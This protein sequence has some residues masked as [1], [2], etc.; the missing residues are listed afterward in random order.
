MWQ[1][2]AATFCRDFSCLPRMF[3]AIYVLAAFL[4]A[5]ICYCLFD[6]VYYISLA[7]FAL[8]LFFLYAWQECR[9]LFG[10][11]DEIKIHMTFH[12]LF[13]KVIQYI[14]IRFALLTLLHNTEALSEHALSLFGYSHPRTYF[15]GISSNLMFLLGRRVSDSENRAGGWVHSIWCLFCGCVL[16]CC[17][18]RRVSM[19]GRLLNKSRSCWNVLLGPLFLFAASVVLQQCGTTIVSLLLWQSRLTGYSWL[20]GHI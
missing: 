7:P 13:F 10:C 4:F 15:M 5:S 16:R 11:R 17:I 18:S 2:L 19:K 14:M 1:T 9:K 3:T 20:S 6:S 12:N 8:C